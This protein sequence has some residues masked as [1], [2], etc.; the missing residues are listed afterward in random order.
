MVLH[1]RLAEV[2][3]TFG[4]VFE[5]WQWRELGDLADEWVSLGGKQ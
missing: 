3:G 5:N 4:K 2:T 1:S